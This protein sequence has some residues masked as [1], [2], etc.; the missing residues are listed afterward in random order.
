MTFEKEKEIT[1]KCGA[2]VQIVSSWANEC[3]T[4]RIEYNGFGETLAPREDWGW[5]TGETF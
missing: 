2:K 1:C 4:C 3:Q 5:E